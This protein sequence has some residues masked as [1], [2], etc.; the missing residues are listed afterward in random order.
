[1]DVATSTSAR[2]RSGAWRAIAR[3]VAAHRKS[4]EQENRRRRPEDAPRHRLD[5]RVVAQVGMDDGTEAFERRRDVV[6]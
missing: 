1:V 4:H 2:T 3:A 6:P 5:R